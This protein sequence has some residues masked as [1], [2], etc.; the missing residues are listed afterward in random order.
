MSFMNG[1]LEQHWDEM[2]LFLQSVTDP[3]SEVAVTG[4]EASVDLAYELSTLH[5][6]LCGIFTGVHQVLIKTSSE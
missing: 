3:D 6:M 5:Y 1:F 4:Y 2:S